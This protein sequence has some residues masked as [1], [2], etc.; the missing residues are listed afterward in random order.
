MDLRR[1]LTS[2]RKMQIKG[3]RRAMI[4][5]TQNWYALSADEAFQALESSH[6]GLTESEVQRRLEQYGPNEIESGEKESKWIL[7]LRQLRNPLVFV[8]IV[9]AVISLLVGKTTD[10]IVIGVVILVNSLIGFIQEA[11]AEDALAALMA[12]AA[13]EAE[14]LR[15]CEETGRLTELTVKASQIVPGDIILLEAG[16]KVP[17]D[18]RL[19]EAANLN[20]DES[21]LTGESVPV[22][23][24]VDTLSGELVTAER[25]NLVYGG[26]L[27]TQGRAKAVVFATGRNTEIGKIAHLIAETEKVESPLHRQV[28]RLSRMVGILAATVSVLTVLIGFGR[29]FEFQEMFLFAL[30]M[31]VSAIPAGLPAVLSITLAIGV[32]RMA[33]RNS[34][35]RR[36]EA[37]DTLGAATAICT[38]K[39]GTLTTNEMTVRQL[40]TLNEL[41]EVTGPGR[42]PHGEFRHDGETADVARHDGAALALRIGVLCNDSHL[43]RHETES[44][45][46]WE[47]RGDPTEG[48]LVV[49]AAKAHL[50]KEALEDDEPRID[51]VP[52]SSATKFM[53]TF[54]RMSGDAASIR[55]YVKGAPETVLG[56]SRWVLAGDEP[57]EMTDE[58]RQQVLEHNEAMA[59]EALR[60]LGL[61][62]RD[63]TPDEMEHF[64]DELQHGRSELVMVGLV[65]MIDPP[66]PE[67]P[68]A[69]AE[70]QRAG[71]RVVMATGDHLLTGQVIA[72]QIGIMREGDGAISGQQMEEMSD[73]DLDAVIGQTSVFARVSPEHKHRIVESL[74]R[75]GHVV[76]M[77]GDGVNDAPALQAS[78]IGVAMGIT[79]TDVTKET[80]DM[81]LTD[82]NFASIVAAV[83][84]GRAVFENVRKVVKYLLATNVG[85][86]ITIL[87]ALMLLPVRE[88]IFTPVQ[89]LWVNLVTDG[90]LDITIAMEPKEGDV[91]DAPPRSANESI[92][93]REIFINIVYVAIFMAVGTLFN[94]TQANSDK[95]IVYARTMAFTTLAMFQVFNA[96]NVR[97]RTKS[98]FRLGLFSNPYLLVAIVVS[99]SLQYMASRVPLFQTM[100]GTETLYAADWLKIILV[101]SS[102][103]VAEELRKFVQ[104]RLRERRAGEREATRA[105]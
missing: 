44:G 25:R 16:A 100:L 8:L 61:A 95:G 73:T 32:N 26:T 3:E 27:V 70:C 85:E 56:M 96:L 76:A 91:M 23:K 24:Q 99:V 62:Y 74:R 105:V 46:H 67:V 41:L 103:F 9:A 10:A 77:T 48:A 68:V 58:R 82:D 65:G 89:L 19:F 75:Q 35:I 72:R 54:H 38:D 47:V 17:A 83:E 36:L 84:E 52:F 102:V 78:E 29:G 37:V 12:Q 42:E 31:I 30:A 43:T 101:S 13:P 88:T 94:F 14:A 63:I 15:D 51:E 104:A 7:F 55:V 20:V 33:R 69:V 45:S 86:I 11:R 97:S 53:A 39:T 21:M 34:I 64:R 4:N 2:Y 28:A 81:V 49:A 60:V 80:A 79:G 90:I 59:G 57:Q 18:A 71:I 5:D 93:S 98:L 87:S 6:R 40:F 92:I 66:R 1:A 50:H 22:S